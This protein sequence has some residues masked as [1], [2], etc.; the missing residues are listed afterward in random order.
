MIPERFHPPRQARSRETLDRILDAVE[1]VMEEK[2]FTDA[3]LAEIMDRAGVTIGAF[4]RR[5]EDKDSLLHL[6]DERFWNEMH[7][8]AAEQLDPGRWKGKSIRQILEEWI[9]VHV[10]LYRSRRGLIRS[11]FL[12][13]R[14]DTVIRETASRVNSYFLRRIRVLLLARRDEIHHP[15]PEYAID[16]A[17]LALVGTLREV[18]VFGE[19]WPNARRVGG[20]RLPMEMTRLLERYLGV[21]ESVA[22]RAGRARRSRALVPVRA[23][24][25]KR[26]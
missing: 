21:E 15:D 18:V 6:L 19:V 2:S 4:Y 9:P 24:M 13:S 11:L 25:R 16:L 8:F 7:D 1:E 12:R 20:P 10:A 26:G 17:L 5:F 14:T 22:P 23:A 3:T